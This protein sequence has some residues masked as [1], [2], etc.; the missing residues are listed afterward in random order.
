M[1]KMIIVECDL[2]EFLIKSM[3]FPK[4]QVKHEGGK[5]KVLDKVRKN[6]N[7]IGIIDEDPNSNQPSEMKK[8]IE[9]K[10]SSTIKLLVRRNDDRKRIIQISPYLEH[11]LLHRARKRRISPS[12]FDVP[13]DPKEMHA[14]PHIERN[15]RFQSFLNELIKTDNEINTLRK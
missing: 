11:W 3:G 10:T 9:K 7:V 4:R 8:Y 5:G 1:K 14:I 6:Q 13:D 12:D 2:D 15:P